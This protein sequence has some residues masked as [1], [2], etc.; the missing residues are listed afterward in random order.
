MKNAIP[1]LRIDI[2]AALAE[3]AKKHGLSKLQA[4]N[5]KYT[6]DSCTFTVE[7]IMEGGLSKE[8]AR[9]DANRGILGLPPLGTEINAGRD[10]WIPTGINTTGSKVIATKKD[11]G[12]SYL[13]GT[14][15]LAAFWKLQDK[16]SATV[17][18]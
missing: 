7:A 4:T 14:E 9:Y 2:N 3:V 13:V 18:S 12:K 1:Q 17:A 11:N 5:A 6:S 8:A 10:I 15:T 16:E